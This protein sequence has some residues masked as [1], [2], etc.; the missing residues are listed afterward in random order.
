MFFFQET[1]LRTPLDSSNKETKDELLTSLEVIE[2]PTTNIFQPR[3]RPALHNS[4]NRTPS[5][6]PLILLEI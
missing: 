1:Q 2:I 4:T 6:T 3:P 5:K